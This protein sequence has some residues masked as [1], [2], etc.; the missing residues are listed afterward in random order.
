M[1]RKYMNERWCVRCHRPGMT[2]FLRTSLGKIERQFAAHNGLVRSEITVAD[3]GCGNGRNLKALAELGYVRLSGYDMCGD[4]E[5]AKTM[6]LGHLPIPEETGAVDLVLA[7]YIFMFLDEAE[8]TQVISEINRMTHHLSVIVIELY[9]AKDSRIT[10]N[11]AMVAMQHSLHREL[12]SKLE[13]GWMWERVRWCK[14]KCVL[15]KFKLPRS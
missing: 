9:P 3:I 11:K 1:S 5:Y 6:L 12:E 10:D 8:T 13:D 4:S 2:P 7:N 14:G 15:R